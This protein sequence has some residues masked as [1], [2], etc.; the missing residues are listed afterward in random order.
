MWECFTESNFSSSPSYEF[1]LV[2]R[3]VFLLL[4]LPVD[5]LMRCA[6]FSVFYFLFRCMWAY[7]PRLTQSFVHRLDRTCVGIRVLTTSNSLDIV[8]T[9]IRTST[10]CLFIIPIT[11]HKDCWQDKVTSICRLVGKYQPFFQLRSRLCH[12]CFTYKIYL[13][14]ADNRET[15]KDGVNREWFRRD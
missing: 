15:Y 11:S 1:P 10:T 6:D 13:Y 9:V 7:D 12:A 2:C 3:P 4:T 14:L 5:L 8:A